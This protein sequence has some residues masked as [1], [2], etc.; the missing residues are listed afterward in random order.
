MHAVNR[1]TY[2]QLLLGQNESVCYIASTLRAH[3]QGHL[4]H[5]MKYSKYSLLFSC[6][7][8]TGKSG[9]T[10]YR[11][12]R[13]PLCR[14][15]IPMRTFADPSRAVLCTILQCRARLL[16]MYAF[17]RR[18]S[19]LS[20]VFTSVCASCSIGCP[21]NVTP[22]C[23]RF[24]VS[25]DVADMVKTGRLR[26]FL[27][28]HRFT[29]FA[30]AMREARKPYRTRKARISVQLACQLYQSSSCCVPSEPCTAARVLTWHIIHLFSYTDMKCGDVFCSQSF[31]LGPVSS[32]AEAPYLFFPECTG[33]KSVCRSHAHTKVSVSHA[34]LALVGI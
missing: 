19:C 2:R 14:F 4:Y 9:V 34:L 17:V 25:A 29:R 8:V 3:P 30:Q 27:E 11:A 7:P 16:L 22:P 13:P 20:C 18:L 21:H 31:L 32:N 10:V 12:P 6:V 1:T 33:H 24:S 28:R 5:L 26:S 15:G 23:A